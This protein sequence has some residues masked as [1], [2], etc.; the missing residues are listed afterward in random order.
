MQEGTTGRR[1]HQ[2]PEGPGAQDGP[3]ERD[4]EEDLGGSPHHMRGRHHP[5]VFSPSD[6]DNL[7]TKVHDA[8]A[9]GDPR[10]AWDATRKLIEVS[11]RLQ[12]EAASSRFKANFG[13]EACTHCEGLKAGPDVSATCFQIQQCYY[14]NI[15][16][17]SDTK[18]TRLIEILSKTNP[19]P[20]SNPD[21]DSK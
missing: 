10:A 1:G 19:D 4:G 18:Q 13:T 7:E 20:N 17:G 9:S 5:R 15:K 12:K 6:L 11:H 14:T 8:F 16:V 21:R 3:G 2:R